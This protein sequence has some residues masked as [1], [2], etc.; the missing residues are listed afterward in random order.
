MSSSSSSAWAWAGSLL[1]LVLSLAAWRF[2]QQQQMPSESAASSAAKR[3]KRKKAAKAKD[4]ERSKMLIQDHRGAA[5]PASDAAA[6]TKPATANAVGGSDDEDDSE[7]EDAGLSA[8]QVLA[9]RRF[10]PKALGGASAQETTVAPFSVQER[11]LARFEGGSEWFPAVI[12]EVG[13]SLWTSAVCML[14]ILIVDL[15]AGATWPDLHAQVRRRRR[16][17]QCAACAD[18]RAF[19]IDR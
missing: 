10:Q 1:V 19:R 13:S 7:D 2:L 5:K 16:G 15:L 6:E 17:A 4:A 18:P 9:K 14:W 12:Q 3:R 8:M 11:V